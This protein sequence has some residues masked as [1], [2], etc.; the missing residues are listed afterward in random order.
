MSGHQRGRS[1]VALSLLVC[2]FCIPE[3]RPGSIPVG[4]SEK[5]VTK[6]ARPAG[7][8]QHSVTEVNPTDYPAFIKTPAMPCLCR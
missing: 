4:S 5:G 2:E 1:G 6:F 7:N 8:E 3:A